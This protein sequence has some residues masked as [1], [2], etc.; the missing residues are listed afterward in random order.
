VC[1]PSAPYGVAEPNNPRVFV[2]ACE[3]AACQVAYDV[4]ARYYFELMRAV[5]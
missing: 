5:A 1:D 4:Q 2:S 3:A